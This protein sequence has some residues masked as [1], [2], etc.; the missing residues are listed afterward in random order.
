[1]NIITPRLYLLSK[2]E[3]KKNILVLSSS[4][5]MTKWFQHHKYYVEFKYIKLKKKGQNYVPGRRYDQ[6]YVFILK[7]IIG[8]VLDI[9]K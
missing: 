9:L 1:M 3:K 7:S 2:T 6:K 8:K 4:I 5:D